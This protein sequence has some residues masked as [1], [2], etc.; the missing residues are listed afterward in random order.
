MIR[1]W[2]HRIHRTTWMLGVPYHSTTESLIG[3]PALSYTTYTFWLKFGGKPTV[4]RCAVEEYAPILIRFYQFFDQINLYFKNIMT[5]L[6]MFQQILEKGFNIFCIP[7]PVTWVSEHFHL[8]LIDCN[9]FRLE[10]YVWSCWIRHL[11]LLR[12]LWIK[13]LKIMKLIVMEVNHLVVSRESMM[14][15]TGNTLRMQFTYAV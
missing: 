2:G 9:S 5:T 14:L 1:S 15:I 7:L 6:I 3:H 8:T 13:K 10:F 4:F 11:S 12:L